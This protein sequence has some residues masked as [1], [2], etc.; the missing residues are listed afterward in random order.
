LLVRVHSRIVEIE[1]QVN[2]IK[3][4]MEHPFTNVGARVGADLDTRLKDWL[5][6]PEPGPEQE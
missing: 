3:H 4:V 1:G 2:R 6:L 5:Q